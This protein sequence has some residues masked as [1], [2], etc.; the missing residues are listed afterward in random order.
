VVAVDDDAIVPRVG[1]PADAV[2]VVCP[3]GPDV[4][5]EHVVAVDL[6]ADRGL[7]HVRAAD[8]EEHVVERGGI[9]RIAV[10]Q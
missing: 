2:S 9:G 6:Q 8:T 10:L 3:P 4:V 7:A 1:G 5:Q